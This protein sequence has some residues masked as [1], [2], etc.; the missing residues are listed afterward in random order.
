MK[1]FRKVKYKARP[2]EVIL[3]ISVSV[4]ELA[5]TLPLVLSFL[6]KT[7]TSQYSSFK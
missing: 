6:S 1:N 4:S 3:Y 7:N 5:E 2:T